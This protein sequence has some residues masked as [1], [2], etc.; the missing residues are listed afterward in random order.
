M[1]FTRAL[2]GDNASHTTPGLTI[3]AEALVLLAAGFITLALNRPFLLAALRGRDWHSADTWG[4]AAA[5]LALLMAVNTLIVGLLCM[6][7]VRKV[8]LALLLVVSALTTHYMQA[9]NV[10]I[11]AS[12]VRSALATHPAEA[13][14]LLS[15]R[16]LADVALFAVLPVALLWP[17][18]VAS[19]PWAGALARRGAL[20]ALAVVVL[21]ATLWAVFQPFSALMRNQRTVRYQITPAN[22]LWS[23]GAVLAA[24]AHGATRPREVLDAQPHLGPSHQQGKPRVLVLMVGETARKANWGLS[25]YARD[26]T[27]ELSQR[28]V[29][30][31]ADVSSCG[32]H[33]EV[34][35]PCMFA[36]VGRRDYDETRIRGNE[37]LLHLLARAGVA[38]HWRDN[39]S[40]CKGVCENLPNDWVN[41]SLAPGLCQ[42]GRCWDEGLLRGLDQRIKTA[43]G[44]QVLVLHMLGNHGPSYFRRYPPAFAHF[45]PACANDDLG[46]CTQ[47][48]IVNAYDNAL[49]YTDHVLA[50]VIDT[51]RSQA[52]TVDS[53][54]VFVSDH[55]ESLGENNLFLHG[56]PYAIAPKQQTEVPM[57]WWM[58][59]GFAS[60]VGLNGACLKQRAAEPASHDQLFHSLLGLLDVRS[61]VYEPAFDLTAACRSGA[62]PKASTAL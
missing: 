46:Q 32:T 7:R 37:S 53:A 17:V 39:Q 16:L 18:Q 13:G 25:G 62:A 31:F 52:A 60:R 8:V 40:G 57:A 24:D 34:S 21:A 12:M 29:L 51:L 11:D 61:T 59:E 14:E 42:G 5:M 56:M 36:P 28:N 48:E 6:G 26:T 38:V 50:T 19:R 47:E 58:T 30:N 27:P 33:T 44:T 41:A 15:W 35:L 55:G 9:Y 20:L 23:L 3:S 2:P 49:R 22:V 1:L 10:V 45:K 43:Q 4:W 54:M